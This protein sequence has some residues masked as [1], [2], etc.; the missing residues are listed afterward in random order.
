LKFA[1][2]YR[3]IKIALAVRAKK[4]AIALGNF[5]SAKFFTDSFRASESISLQSRK[6]FSN[7]IGV[8][9]VS[10]ITPSK[11]FNNSTFIS[12]TG[13]DYFAED[14]VLGDYTLGPQF[15]WELG[16][17]IFEIP[18]VQEQLTLQHSKS[19]TETVKAIDFLGG[20]LDKTDKTIDYFDVVGNTSSV[21][22]QFERQVDYVRSF[23]ELT[24]IVDSA[25]ISL[26]RGVSNSASVSDNLAY[27]IFIGVPL[28]N[29][30][31]VADSGSLLAQGY[32]EDM[33]Y[34]AEDYVG[35]SR[36]FT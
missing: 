9:D 24:S 25:A 20:E 15:V 30:S 7:P 16:K 31:S 8:Q 26:S 5:I 22:D 4:L 18:T 27:E 12:D 11:N 28:A 36:T 23:S 17:N 32:T 14:Y 33:T 1:I 10:V 2:S 6:S 19:F 3:V 13:G 21:A 29:S 35:E 34:F